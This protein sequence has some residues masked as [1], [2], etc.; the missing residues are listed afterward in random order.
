MRSQK[1][2]VK[3]YADR[4]EAVES[5]AAVPVF[6]TWIREHKIGDGELLIDVANYS[7]VPKGPGVAL[8]GHESD[9]F[10]DQGEGRLGLLYSRKRGFEGD[11]KACVADAFRRALVACRLLEK[12]GSV[13]VRFRTNEALVRIQDR[14]NAPNTAETFAELEPVLREVLAR[15]YDG[16]V[17]LEHVA[18]ARAPFTVRVRTQAVDGVDSLL[19]RVS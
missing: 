14:L 2:Q 15:L 6:H 18:D 8:I 16:E 17:Q 5:E 1:I 4:P 10:L 12:E 19:A 9:Y 7:H 13:R 11:A 3:F